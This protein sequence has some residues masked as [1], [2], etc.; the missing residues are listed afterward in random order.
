MVHLCSLPAKRAKL[1]SD[2]VTEQRGR[3]ST[4]A[5]AVWPTLDEEL[6]V[7]SASEHISEYTRMFASNLQTQDAVLLAASDTSPSTASKY[8]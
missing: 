5:L 3:E 6:G 2:V 1:A 7:L 4:F 8:T